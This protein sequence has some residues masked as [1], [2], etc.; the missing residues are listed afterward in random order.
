MKLMGSFVLVAVFLHLAIDAT[1]TDFSEGTYLEVI[2][3]T[4]FFKVKTSD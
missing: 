4:A 1:A 2:G 3:S